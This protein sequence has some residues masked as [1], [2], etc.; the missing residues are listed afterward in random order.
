MSQYTRHTDIVAMLPRPV[1][2]GR[3]ARRRSSERLRVV[4][5]FRSPVGGLFRHVRDLVAVQRDAGYDVGIVCDSSTGGAFEDALFAEI[6]PSLSL[7][8]HRFPMEREISLSDGLATLRALREIRALRPDVVHAHGAKGGAYARMIGTL[9]RFTGHRVARVYTPHGGSMHFDPQSREGRTYFAMERM[10]G[11]M[12]DAFV[13]VSQ[14]EADAYAAKVGEPRA[15]VSIALNGLRADEFEPVAPA[16]DARDFVFI[17]MM[18]AMKGAE[19]FLRALGIIRDRT[20]RSPSAWMIGDG[21]EQPWFCQLSKVLG[22]QKAVSFRPA[23]PARAAFAMARTVVAP[24]RAESMPY[25]ILEALAAGV[26][27][28]TTRVGGIPEI[29]G[30]DSRLL[31]PPENPTALADAMMQALDDRASMVANAARLRAAIRSRFAVETMA[32]KVTD[33]YR[34]VVTAR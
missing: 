4:H 21:D 19:D 28:L 8:L 17:G 24:S 7:G 2:I 12:T 1:V 14:Y 22:I 15:A 32:A 9:L 25:L 30:E 27:T 26:P 5:F 31:L 20:G 11:H 18:R 34:A 6:E 10:L 13:F 29:F 3:A 23:M 16:P 33:A